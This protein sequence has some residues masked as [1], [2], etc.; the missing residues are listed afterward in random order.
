MAQASIDP[1]DAKSIALWAAERALVAD[2]SCRLWQSTTIDGMGFM[3]TALTE[4]P[5]TGLWTGV[6]DLDLEDAHR[7]AR[8]GPRGWPAM[9]RVADQIAGILGLPTIQPPADPS[10]A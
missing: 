10:P 1:R 7:I 8:R 2:A 6:I 5:R 4:Q 9:V 3:V